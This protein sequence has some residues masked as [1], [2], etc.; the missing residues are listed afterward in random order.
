MAWSECVWWH[1]GRDAHVRWVGMVICGGWVCVWQ[2]WV[3][4][5]GWKAHK[6]MMPLIKA[7]Y[8]Q[9]VLSD[10]AILDWAAEAADR[11]P[12]SVKL[13]E[14]CKQLLD[15]LEESEDDDD[16]DDEEEEEEEEEE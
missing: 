16:D 12:G 9:D 11:G 6:L 5:D 3:V 15:Y 1:A 2:G 4:S 13:K 8:D 14:E 10:D 7:C